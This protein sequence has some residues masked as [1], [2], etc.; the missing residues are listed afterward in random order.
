MTQCAQLCMLIFQYSRQLVLFNGAWPGSFVR[1][2]VVSHSRWSCVSLIH[3][4]KAVPC[5]LSLVYSTSYNLKPTSKLAFLRIC[6][7]T[8]LHS[9]LC[10]FTWLNI[11]QNVQ[12]RQQWN[13]SRASSCITG[14]RGYQ[15][16]GTTQMVVNNKCAFVTRACRYR[17]G[18]IPVN[19]PVPC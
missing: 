8:S 9:Q 13:F 1:N 18:F 16:S 14:D 4:S 7:H 19:V 17:Q 6:Q 12:R 15:E 10:W 2:Q 3:L 5:L 11:R